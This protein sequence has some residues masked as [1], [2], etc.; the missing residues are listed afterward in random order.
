[1]ED[2]QGLELIVEAAECLKEKPVC[3]VLCGDGPARLRIEAMAEQL[4]NIRFIPLQ[5]MRR[6][7]ELLNFADI[8]LLP[9]R[10]D[11]TDLVMPSKLTGMLASGRPVVAT[12]WPNTE[13]EQ[14][15]RLCGVV[16]APGDA[17]VFADAVLNLVQDVAQR[18]RL[19]HL[20]REVAERNFSED[21]VLATLEER[22]QAFSHG[23]P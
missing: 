13:I 15:L 17:Q 2:N 8:H 22:L 10:A 18:Q 21:S 9:Q 6:L 12:A 4:D 14:V 3:F 5:P 16:V 7:N 1:M 20:A 19:G 23:S 11:A